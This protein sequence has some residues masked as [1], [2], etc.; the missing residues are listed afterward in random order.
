[1][2]RGVCADADLVM[3]RK[4]PGTSACYGTLEAAQGVCGE[5]RVGGGIGS[6][7]AAVGRACVRCEGR[8]VLCD[9]HVRPHVE[10]HICDECA[11]GSGAETCIVCG[12]K[13]V[14]A[15]F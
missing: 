1:M 12:A 9:S 4:L 5:R 7:C 14:S 6:A 2:G 11:Y 3:C 8:C 13:G 15:A 10:T